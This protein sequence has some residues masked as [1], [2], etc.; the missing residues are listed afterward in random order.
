MY[1]HCTRRLCV[2]YNTEQNKPNMT[3][4]RPKSTR[5]VLAAQH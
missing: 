2:Y 1:Q 4:Y 5:H 3:Q